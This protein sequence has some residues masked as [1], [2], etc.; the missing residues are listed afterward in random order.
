S[1]DWTAR[2]AY[3]PARA[4]SVTGTAGSSREA[5]DGQR[6]G[7]QA[8]AARGVPAVT[9]EALAPFGSLAIPEGP[10]ALRPTLAAGLPLS[11]NPAP[12]YTPGRLSFVAHSVPRAASSAAAGWRTR[13]AESFVRG[14]LA[15][16]NCPQWPRAS[17]TINL[18]TGLDGELRF[19]SVT[20]GLAAGG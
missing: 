1:L 20:L 12:G 3:R 6:S 2:R 15:R 8:P 10:M 19:Q 14:G 16:V 7:D 9:G 18:A 11:R 17:R 13:C 5:T 4:R